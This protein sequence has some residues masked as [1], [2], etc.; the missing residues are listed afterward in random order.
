MKM[1][2]TYTC[3]VIQ[4]PDDEN[5]LA[6]QFSD[7]LLA[8]TGWKTGDVLTWEE[9]DGGWTLTKKLPEDITPES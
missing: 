1:S 4:D 9:I 5:G 7:E 8:D 3:N 2:K 6:I